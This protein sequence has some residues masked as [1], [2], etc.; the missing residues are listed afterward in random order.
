MAKRRWRSDVLLRVQLA[1]PDDP[2]LDSFSSGVDEV[3]EYFRSR[4]WFSATSGKA[5]PP[6]YQFRTAEGGD[7]VGYA[8]VSFRSC[9]HPSDDSETKAKY[10]VVYAAGLQGRFQG[11]PNPRV[12]DETDRPRCA[13]DAWLKDV[14]GIKGIPIPYGA[15]NAAFRLSP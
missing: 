2:D 5:A 7:V 14:M 11:K 8:A 1:L 13:L 3:D 12:P 10:L 4:Q 15:P 6:T 9:T